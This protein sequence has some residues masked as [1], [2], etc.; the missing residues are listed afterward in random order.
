[1]QRL[2]RVRARVISL[3][4]LAWL[5]WNL[6]S[7]RPQTLCLK[8][9]AAFHPQQAETEKRHLQSSFSW[10]SQQHHLLLHPVRY[11]M[12]TPSPAP[13]P[14]PAPEREGVVA[15]RGDERAILDRQLHG[16]P[17]LEGESGAKP[18][19]QQYA[20]ATDRV[21]LGVAAICAVVAGAVN[22]LV[23]V[24]CPNSRPEHNARLCLLA[25][26]G[27]RYKGHLWPVRGRLRGF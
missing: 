9:F 11:D 24:R 25:N 4:L 17:R 14:A 18:T 5:K 6:I 20:N 1:M 15:V 3:I 7:A 10:K 13:A 8:H 22:P 2:N 21:V 16:L 19:I 12:T 26:L 23:P 27:A